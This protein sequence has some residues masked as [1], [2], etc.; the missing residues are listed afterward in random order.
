[1]HAALCPL[2]TDLYTGT[3]CYRPL[4]EVPKN[5]RVQEYICIRLV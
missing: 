4:P 2:N 5:V 3:I 1:L